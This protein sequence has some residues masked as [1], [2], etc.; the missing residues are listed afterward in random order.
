MNSLEEECLILVY[1]SSTITN[2]F[3]LALDGHSAD[4]IQNKQVVYIPA[5]VSLSYASVSF[6][7]SLV[8][9]I[10]GSGLYL[11]VADMPR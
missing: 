3:S 8:L 2:H 5:L 4:R 11:A 1:K 6:F 10:T 7:C 9:L